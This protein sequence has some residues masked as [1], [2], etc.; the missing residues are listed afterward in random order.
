M[1]MSFSHKFRFNI[2]LRLGSSCVNVGRS[3]VSYEPREGATAHGSS[4]MFFF[5]LRLGYY[6]HLDFFLF[7]AQV[8]R[9]YFVIILHP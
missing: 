7:S 4:F 5:V 3:V 1:C 9:G 8:A 2:D 6:S